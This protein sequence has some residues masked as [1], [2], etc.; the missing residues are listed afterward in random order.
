MLHVHDGV[1]LIGIRA[2]LSNLL[3]IHPLADPSTIQY[4]ALDNLFYHGHNLSVFWDPKS[5]QWPQ[6]KK[7]GCKA[8]LCIFVDSKVVKTSPMLGRVELTLQT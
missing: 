2:A 4:F 3:I 1:G 5:E 8:G 6:L 7:A